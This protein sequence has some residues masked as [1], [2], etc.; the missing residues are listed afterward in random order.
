MTLDDVVNDFVFKLTCVSEVDVLSF[1]HD[2]EHFDIIVGLKF[3][4]GQ[5]ASLN[6]IEGHHTSTV[7]DV[8]SVVVWTKKEVEGTRRNH[9][10]LRKY[11][12]QSI[13]E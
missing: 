12:A 2:G 10:P 5:H 4:D 6:A 1:R 7:I 8:Y 13:E 3:F 9:T 11:L